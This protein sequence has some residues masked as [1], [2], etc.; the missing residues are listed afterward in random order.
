[1]GKLKGSIDDEEKRRKG[2]AFRKFV[3]LDPA[4]PFWERLR[5]TRRGDNRTKA[6]NFALSPVTL[7]FTG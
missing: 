6:Q 5:G 4:F 1:M 2:I 7:F 3:D